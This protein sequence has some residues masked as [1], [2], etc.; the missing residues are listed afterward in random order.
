MSDLDFLADLVTTGTV[1][2]LDHTS[3][4]DEVVAVFG[5]RVAPGRPSPSTPLVDFA[6]SRG[7][8]GWEVDRCEAQA[9]RLGY[10]GGRVGDPLVARYGPFRHEPLPLDELVDAVGARGFALVELTGPG[11]RHRELLAPA[12]GVVVRGRGDADGSVRSAWIG[13]GGRRRAALHR[14][15]GREAEFRRAAQRL[16]AVPEPLLRERLSARVGD[17]REAEW[18][19]LSAAVRWSTGRAQVE[20]R[21]R[22]FRVA[23]EVGPV[24]PGE[25]ALLVARWIRR[26]PELAWRTPD[27]AARD[28]LAA[29]PANPEALCDRVLDEPGTAAARALRDQVHELRLLIPLLSPDVADELRPWREMRSRLLAPSS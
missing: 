15:A 22:V 18:A 13:A 6:W 20:R 8:L 3:G 4:V 26:R 10:L 7:P 21:A 9:H 14:A 23:V 27:Q 28:W 17:D 16:V 19:G 2:G 1:L 11:A 12:S 24:P 29:A 5:D 25:A